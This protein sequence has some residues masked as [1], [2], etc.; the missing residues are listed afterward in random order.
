MSIPNYETKVPEN[1]RKENAEKLKTY[2]TELKANE[3]ST[4]ELS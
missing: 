2:E 3:K 1:V 4:Q